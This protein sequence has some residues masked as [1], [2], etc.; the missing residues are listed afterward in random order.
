[1]SPANELYKSP[2]R[3]IA[4]RL[5]WSYTNSSIGD[6]TLVNGQSQYFIAAL[7]APC[8]L[9]P[10]TGIT[11]INDKQLCLNKVFK[12]PK[13]QYSKILFV[14]RKYI[15]LKQLSR[16]NHY[17]SPLRGMATKI[18]LSQE[19]KCTGSALVSIPR[20]RITHCMF[21][22]VFCAVLFCLACVAG[23]LK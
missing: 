20:G 23:A 6:T 9:C 3:I 16:S 22:Y 7:Q 15:Y 13:R 21:N 5:V 10:C 1:M 14:K 4:A 19:S 17:S 18:E 12:Q 8:E 11:R 2:L